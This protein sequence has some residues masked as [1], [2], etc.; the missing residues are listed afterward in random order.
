[1][2][3]F[4]LRGRADFAWVHQIKQSKILFWWWYSLTTQTCTDSGVL[5]TL[6][7]VFTFSPKSLHLYWAVIFQQ[8]TN[9]LSQGRVIRKQPS[10]RWC[11]ESHGRYNVQRITD[12]AEFLWSV[13][14]QEKK[15]ECLG[16]LRQEPR[17]G[18]SM[19]VNVDLLGQRSL[20]RS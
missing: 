12:W 9:T 15:R 6:S 18:V 19:I 14:S 13:W 10:M 1:M 4:T 3:F 20:W 8:M 11:F 17:K 2:A 5:V 16:I 7:F